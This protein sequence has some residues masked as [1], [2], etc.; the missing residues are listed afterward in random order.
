MDRDVAV[1]FLAL[2]NSDVPN[3]GY[4]FRIPSEIKS[5]VIMVVEQSPKQTTLGVASKASMEASP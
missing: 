1:E 5:L 4:E 2:D 3:A